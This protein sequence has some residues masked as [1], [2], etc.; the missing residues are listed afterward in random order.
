MFTTVIPLRPD[1][2]YERQELVLSI[3]PTEENNTTVLRKQIKRATK[4]V[5][6]MVECF[7]LI[8]TLRRPKPGLKKIGKP[9]HSTTV[10]ANL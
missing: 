10:N 7:A 1:G 4:R 6:K 2:P 5:D 9:V 8:S 3:T